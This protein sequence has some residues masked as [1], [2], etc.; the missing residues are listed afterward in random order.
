MIHSTGHESRLN[1]IATDSATTKYN[2]AFE[3]LIAE[4]GSAFLCAQFAIGGRLQHAAYLHSYISAIKEDSALI[5]KAAA[6]A[7][8]AF[9]AI[10]AIIPAKNEVAA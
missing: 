8:K 1:R 3:E 4:I 9:D 5:Y 2:Y 7:Q 10:M 6:G